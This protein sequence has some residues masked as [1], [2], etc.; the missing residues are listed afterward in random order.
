MGVQQ[1]LRATFTKGAVRFFVALGRLDGFSLSAKQPR[2]LLTP[3][4]YG[5]CSFG[6][7]FEQDNP[8]KYWRIS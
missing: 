1:D 4:C 8:V 6:H 5:T 7:T 3:D 2:Q